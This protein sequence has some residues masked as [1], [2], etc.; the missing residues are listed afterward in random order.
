MK[1]G[2][3][4]GLGVVALAMVGL[5]FTQNSSSMWIK[6]IIYAGSNQTA[7]T[8]ATGTLAFSASTSLTTSITAFAGGGQASAVQLTSD[9]NIVTVCATAADSVKLVAAASGRTQVVFNNGVAALAVFPGTGDTI[10]GAAAD[11]SVTVPVNGMATFRGLS[12]S[13]WKVDPMYDV[14]GAKEYTGA[15]AT[16]KLTIPDNLADAFNI[17]EGAN[18]YMK[19][20]ST[21][22][23]ETVTFTPAVT[24]TVPSVLS[25]T[26]A[27]SAAG[28]S[29]TDATL[30]TKEINVVTTATALQGVELLTAVVG[31]HQHIYN[32]TAVTVIVY[33][34]D[35]GND[36]LAVNDLAALTADVGYAMGPL[37]TMDCIAYTTTAWHCTYIMGA[38]STVAGAGTNQ[39]TGTALASATMGTSVAVTAAD[40][41]VAVTLPTGGSS[42]TY[43]PGCINIQSTVNTNTAYLPVF[44]NNSDNDTINGAAADAVFTMGAGASVT[45]CTIDGVAWLT[46]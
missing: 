17:L 3:L 10:N 11:A 19:I 23:A 42:T 25:I 4:A 6:G 40:A 31:Q 27:V 21:N 39:A 24:F 36:T 37:S 28:S 12:A 45:F 22:S 35:A 32:A 20:V 1:R 44:G 26:A 13:A 43:I 7:L 15:T 29:K 9:F 33:P 38:R 8:D 34:L 14:N 41:T 18:S 30:L 5:G 2:I 46:R 16:N